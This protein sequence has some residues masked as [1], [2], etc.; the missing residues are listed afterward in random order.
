MRALLGERGGGMVCDWELKLLRGMKRMGGEG[1][2]DG[3]FRRV[4]RQ[5]SSINTIISISAHAEINIGYA[6][7]PQQR[8]DQPPH[9]QILHVHT[10]KA[11]SQ[12]R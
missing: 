3:H 1:S 10:N 6:W 8:K 9:R 7:Q 12:Q 11:D 5:L 2:C 4:H